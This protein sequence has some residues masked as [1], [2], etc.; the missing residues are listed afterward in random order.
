MRPHKDARKELTA[1]WLE[2][3]AKD[4]AVGKML[5]QKGE[6]YFDFACFHCQQSAEKVVKAFL[7][8]HDTPFRKIH[9]LV[10][11]GAL[12]LPIDS[13]LEGILKSTALL[14]RY[15][16]DSRYP[17]EN[18]EEYTLEQTTEALERANLVLVEILKRLPSELQPVLSGKA[19]RSGKVKTMIVRKRKK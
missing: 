2:K 9:D 16:V 1:K 14:S 4:L 13:S 5:F 7:V 19:V 15:A 8:W 17:G 12:C 3:A 11:L 6:T 10:S 18:S